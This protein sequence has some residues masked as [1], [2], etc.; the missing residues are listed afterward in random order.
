MEWRIWMTIE[1][2]VI[3]P[4]NKEPLIKKQEVTA[5]ALFQVQA[6]YF[7][8]RERGILQCCWHASRIIVQQVTEGW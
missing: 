6:D 7:V 4:G 1:F 8:N 5:D 3:I 2:T